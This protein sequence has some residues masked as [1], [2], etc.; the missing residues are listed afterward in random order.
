MLLR[1]GRGVLGRFPGTLNIGHC[2]LDFPRPFLGHLVGGA[3]ATDP[4][5]KNRAAGVALAERAPVAVVVDRGEP[6]LVADMGEGHRPGQLKCAE[7]SSIGIGVSITGDGRQLIEGILCRQRRRL[8]IGRIRPIEGDDGEIVVVGDLA[9]IARSEAGIVRVHDHFPGAALLVSAGIGGRHLDLHL[10]VHDQAQAGGRR[11]VVA[12][13]VVTD[14]AMRSRQHP[15]GGDQCAGTDGL[16]NV[17]SGDDDGGD[18]RKFRG[19]VHFAAAA[20]L[21]T[22]A[23]AG[24][25]QLAKLRER[26]IAIDQRA[27]RAACPVR[28]RV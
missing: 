10:V 28:V 8:D 1:F 12:G 21:R 15:A 24:R 13:A 11:A 16:S 5:G 6:Q 2:A 26:D 22:L 3:A 19:A 27:V 4:V 9:D 18:F 14:E 20:G 25:R 17:R 7:R 23:R